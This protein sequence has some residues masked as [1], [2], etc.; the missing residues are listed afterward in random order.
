MLAAA[1]CQEA[2]GGHAAVGRY[3]HGQKVNPSPGGVDGAAS[4][5][6]RV[7][8]RSRS[9]FV[10]LLVLGSLSGSDL[11]MSVVR[12][13]SA[14]GSGEACGQISATR[15]STFVGVE[16]SPSG[17]ADTGG[18]ADEA[19]PPSCVAAVRCGGSATRR[20]RPRWWAV[21][22]G[23][24]LSATAVAL[25]VRPSLVKVSGP[26]GDAPKF[27]TFGGGAA[28]AFTLSELIDPSATLS[29]AKLR[30]RPVL[31]NF[32]ASWCVDCRKEAPLLEA[33]YRRVGARVTF[34]GVD[35]NDTRA[36]ALSF[37]HEFG[38][39]YPSVYDPHGTAATAYGLFGLPTTVFVSPGGRILER[40]VGVLTSGSLDQGIT[41]LLR[42]TRHRSSAR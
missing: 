35:T 34:V 19:A 18:E 28:P 40:N 3:G 21:A 27:V 42:S 15:C 6:G 11:G 20:R 4:L 33:A 13:M 14:A 24:V 17:V 22:I 10:H 38:V 8:S 31:V 1:T 25:V 23:L 9:V 39:T 37:L 16:A 32:W 12:S 30:G 36:A 41:L 5:L 26:G 2:A 7:Q 29:L